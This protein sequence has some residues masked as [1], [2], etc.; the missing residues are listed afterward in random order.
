MSV[1]SNVLF[2]QILFKYGGIAFEVHSCRRVSYESL[3]F[4]VN[5]LLTV[6]LALISVKFDRAF[7][8]FKNK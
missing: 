3:F 2:L 4:L 7:L 8:C 6:H 5:V 1:L